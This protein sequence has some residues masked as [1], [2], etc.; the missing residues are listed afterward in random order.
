MPDGYGYAVRQA[1]ALRRFLDDGRLHMTNN[2]S[3][4]ALR[5]IAV[6]V[7]LCTLSS[8]TRNLERSLVARNSR[9][10]ACVLAAAA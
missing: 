3:E 1:S 7:S 9:R 2:H 10:A 6:D 4:R 8:S 5:G